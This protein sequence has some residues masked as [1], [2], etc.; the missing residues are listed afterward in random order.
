MKAAVVR[1]FLLPPRYQD[2]PDPVARRQ[3]EVVVQVLAAGLHP[4]VRSQAG[5]FHYTSTDELPLIPG[6]D[7]VVRDSEREASATRFSTTRPSGRWPSGP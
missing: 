7:A 5:G 4:R 6:I 3:G 1:R 2:F